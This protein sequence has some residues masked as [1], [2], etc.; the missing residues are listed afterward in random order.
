[1]RPNIF[2]PRKRGNGTERAVF[3]DS[4][5]SAESQDSCLS[6]ETANFL[7]TIL[8]LIRVLKVYYPLPL[9]SST[10]FGADS[11]TLASFLGDASRGGGEFDVDTETRCSGT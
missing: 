4:E 11:S 7:E 1:M 3:P 8:V 5:H 6:N 2:P 9:P 10:P